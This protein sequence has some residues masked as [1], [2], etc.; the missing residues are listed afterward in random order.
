MFIYFFKGT[1]RAVQPRKR[2]KQTFLK[3]GETNNT[4][5]IKKGFIRNLNSFLFLIKASDIIPH[6]LQ[7][8]NA[9]LFYF[10]CLLLHTPTYQKAVMR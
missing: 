4:V 5:S 7:N 2:E 1:W 6:T 10:A 3:N 9:S 8:N